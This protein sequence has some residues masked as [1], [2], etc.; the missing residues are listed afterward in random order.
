MPYNNFFKPIKS[1]IKHGLPLALNLHTLY[2]F[3]F[4]VEWNLVFDKKVNK[5]VKL[6]FKI[7][8]IKIS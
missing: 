4:I 6:N 3:E 1:K 7:K 5:T 2:I 8:S